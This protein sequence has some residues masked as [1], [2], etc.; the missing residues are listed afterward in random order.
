M[1]MAAALA[2]T[3]YGGLIDYSIPCNAPACTVVKVWKKPGSLPARAIELPRLAGVC[4][5]EHGGQLLNGQSFL[6]VT[7][8][9]DALA[10][11]ARLLRTPHIF[12]YDAAVPDALGLQSPPPPARGPTAG[13]APSGGGGSAGGGSAGGGDG[14]ALAGGEE[15]PESGAG[16]G[17]QPSSR[18]A[19]AVSGSR[20]SHM[21]ADRGRVSAWA[22]AARVARAAADLAAPASGAGAGMARAL[23]VCFISQS[24]NSC[25]TWTFAVCL[26]TERSSY[27]YT[28]SAPRPVLA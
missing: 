16:G 10:A 23:P 27:T 25:S 28:E 4:C 21:D 1:C 8:G 7:L 17:L 22:G 11:A 14:G 18:G 24:P 26:Y 5:G 9:A 6:C 20:E 2:L 12:I 15:G 19:A 3:S 13:P